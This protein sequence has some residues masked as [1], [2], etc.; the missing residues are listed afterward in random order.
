MC[1]RYLFWCFL[2]GSLS[3][4]CISGCSRETAENDAG[5]A[6]KAGD[7]SRE[8][9]EEAQITGR[10]PVREINARGRNPFFPNFP[11][12]ETG[13]EFTNH[14]ESRNLRKYLLNGAGVCSGDYDNDGRVDLYLVCQDGPNKLYRQVDRWE[15]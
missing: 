4:A 3:Y 9:I 13:I 15:V 1:G 11:S 14:L 8:E 12:S 6:Y 10:I 5:V 2:I 7:F